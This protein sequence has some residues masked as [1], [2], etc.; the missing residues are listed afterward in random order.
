M[1]QSK[2]LQASLVTMPAGMNTI[3][4]PG[5]NTGQPA[6]NCRKWGAQIKATEK[7][8]EKWRA[9]KKAAKKAKKRNRR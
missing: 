8:V 6:Q 5:N 4:T 9:K 1:K 7:R 2:L 3:P